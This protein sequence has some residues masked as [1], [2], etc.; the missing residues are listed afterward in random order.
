MPQKVLKFTGINRR[1]NEFQAAGACEELINIRP[2]VT[3]LEVVK[4]KKIKFEDVA[5]DIYNHTF[6][7]Y[8]NFI[9][10]TINLDEY[11]RYI[12]Y[13]YLLDSDDGSELSLIDSFLVSSK[14]YD[15]ELIGNQVILSHDKQLRTYVFQDNVYKRIDATV[16]DDIK[17]TYT[18]SM[19]Y[20]SNTET[21]IEA[22][23][24][25]SNLFKEEAVKT[26]SAALGQNN[27]KE[28]IFGPVVVAMNYSLDDG[29]EFWTNKFIYINP[30]ASLPLGDNGVRMI[31]YET[32]GGKYFVYDSFALRFTIPKTTVSNPNIKNKVTSVNIYASR[33]VFPYDLDTM[34]A[35][36]KIHKREI[37][38]R[39]KDMEASGVTNEVLY[40]QKSIPIED[41]EK[42]DVSFY[43]DFG[44]TQAG[45]AVMEVDNG[46]VKRAGKIAVYNNRLHVYN[47]FDTIFPQSVVCDNTPASADGSISD[48]FLERDAY[49]HIA[50][51]AETLVLKTKAYVRPVDKLTQ[52]TKT[53]ACC[54]P[55]A[56]AT[57][58]M[59]AT[60]ETNSDFCRVYLKPSDRYNFAYGETDYYANFSAEEIRNTKNYIYEASAI[61]VSEQYNPFVF[62]V[63]N[64]YRVG[65]EIL[66]LATSYIPI[67]STQ[68]GQFP[69]TVFTTNGIFALEQGSNGLL[70]GNVL[71]IQPHV[72]QGKAKAT[73]YG[74]FFISSNSLYMLSGREAV[75]VSMPMRG[76][77]ELN[78]REN[79]SYSKILEGFGGHSELVSFVDFERYTEGAVL[80]YDQLN[81]E[82]Y[83]CN[84]NDDIEYSYVFN[85]NTKLFHKTQWKLMQS[86]GYRYA[87]HHHFGALSYVDLFEEDSSSGFIFL[88]S[89]PFSLEAFYTHIQRLI[90]QIDA[91]ITGDQ[92][93]GLFVFAS[94][95][96]HDW[97]CIISA[98][99][100]ETVLRHIR[101]NRAAKSYKDY[102]II[103]S[104]TVSTDTDLSDLIADYTVVSRRLG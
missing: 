12:L 100:K 52:V 70:Y 26:W 78:I 23:D 20:G 96:L 73:P 24:P 46:P 14:E 104:G 25:K 58:I 31:Y 75:D 88:Q 98:Q 27:Q 74:I 69:I 80:A 1:V 93:L 10:V 85:I 94:D 3:G 82:V 81:N 2:T 86:N 38:G 101:T 91:N 45:K 6:S 22:S 55:D 60:D 44:A 7:S 40:F 33:P 51:N 37:Y 9:G 11:G 43:L 13:V 30:F 19:S 77:H 42:G 29:T 57:K 8:S 21:S 79:P 50:C 34:F 41:I 17:I 5:Y 102:A 89:R 53:I 15:L 83:I 32:D 49:V 92:K 90:M 103:L 67:S 39:V 35:Q 66:D 16:P 61:S 99:K 28:A 36:S 71:P 62:P 4:P 97:K 48:T 95:N 56:R 63:I 84:L 65:G 18:R 59:I 76:P 68:I 47:S 87:L 64:S 54:Y 72:I